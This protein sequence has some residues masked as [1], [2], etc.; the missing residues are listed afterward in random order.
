MDKASVNYEELSVEQ[1]FDSLQELLNTM[2]NPEATLEES[3]QLYHEGVNMVRA[4][5]SK[6]DTIEKQLITLREENQ[7]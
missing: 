6:I 3:F 2:E 5:S 7:D 4:C 1:L